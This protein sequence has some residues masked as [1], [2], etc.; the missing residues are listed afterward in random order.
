MRHLRIVE[1]MG[2]AKCH[3]KGQQLLNLASN[4]YLGLATDKALKEEFIQEMVMNDEW[5]NFGASS[6]RLLTGNMSLYE[7]VEELL[8]ASY[9]VEA[10]LFFNSGYHANMGILPALAEKGDLILSDKLCHASIIDGIRLSQAE[11]LRFRHSDYEQLQ[12]ILEKERHLYK[13]VFVVV[14][15]V[16][17][18][19]GDTADLAL[20]V[21]LREKY[22][23]LLYVDEAHAVGVLGAN[24]LGL[25]EQ[26]QM[27]QK[28]DIIVGTLGKAYASVGAF[29]ITSQT[30]KKLLVN[31][32][33]TLIY[34]TA[35]PPVNMAW[36]KFII[37]RMPALKPH[38]EHLH[39]LAMY[40]QKA[41]LAKGYEVH[42][43][44]IMP[45]MLGANEVAVQLSEHLQKEGF[46]V[47]PIRPPTVPKNTARLRISLT[48]NMKIRDLKKLMQFIPDYKAK[49]DE[50]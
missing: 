18:M 26:Q 42:K 15:S 21:E 49:R 20:L 30:F 37:K 9:K 34:T 5:M 31:K 44:H 14:E 46:L 8:R 47:F 3:Y 17:S 43:S 27:T 12:A 50:K 36:T 33:R 45:V 35:L 10:A 6:S 19:D 1:P 40:M 23:C 13:R 32:A 16:Y 2:D 38:R 25:C 48:A 7:E 39:E 29:A 28:I 41:L 24:G 4:D 22:N 11:H